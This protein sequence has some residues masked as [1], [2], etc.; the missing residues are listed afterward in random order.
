MLNSADVAG[1]ITAVGGVLTTFGLGIRF[2]IGR[3]D[4]REQKL[5]AD[6]KE[7]RDDLQRMMQKQLDDLSQAH[8]ALATRVDILNRDNH[9]LNRHV[10][11]LIGILQAHDLTVPEEVLTRRAEG[12]SAATTEPEG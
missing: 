4:L 1:T 11:I 12:D 3:I 9:I 5:Q 2:V 8:V 6:E 10:G 7:A